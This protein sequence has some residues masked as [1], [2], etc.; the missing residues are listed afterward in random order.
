MRAGKTHNGFINLRF[1]IS[2]VNAL[3]LITVFISLLVQADGHSHL[4]SQTTF[5]EKLAQAD[6]IRS[7]QPKK[8]VKL[9][10]QL[11]QQTNGITDSQQ[12]SLDY[13]NIYLLMYQGDLAAAATAAKALINSDT[14]ALLKFRA[15]IALVNAYGVSQNWTEGLSSL[16]SMLA[17]LPLIDEK[18]SY[19][20]GILI[21]AIFYNQIGQYH[22]GLSYA[23]KAESISKHGR[24][25]CIAKAQIIESSFKLKQLTSTSPIIEHAISIC[26]IND[27]PLIINFIHSYVAKLYLENQQQDKALS[28]LNATLED[29]LNTNYSRIIAEYYA[30]LAQAHWLNNNANLTKQF[31]LKVLEYEKKENTT[32]AKVSAYK[33]LFEVYRTQK[34]YE[35]ALL[36]H[37]KFAIADKLYDSETQAKHLAFQ[38]AEHKSIAQQSKIDLLSQQNAL[39][40]SEQAL[41]R[42]NTEKTRL[43]IMVLALTLAVLTFWGYRLL[44]AHKLIKKMAEYDAL[45]D[46]F[47]RGHFTHVANNTIEY[48]QSTEQALSVIMFDL[49][50]FKK[51]NDNYGHACGDWALKKA[52]MVCQENSRQNDVFARLGGEEFCIILTGCDKRAALKHAEICRLAIANID[53]SESGF[54][55]NITASFGITDS[56]TSGYNLEKLLADADEAAYQAKDLGRN[57]ISIYENE[58][59]SA[60]VIMLEDSPKAT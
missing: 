47:N 60:T 45:T 1:V 7:S 43:I 52:V 46:I 37:Q 36:Y 20:Q 44:N 58:Q 5:D 10:K 14:S 18:K 21:S 19:A 39:L 55:F 49:D 22:L 2:S 51:V 59:M 3:I 4:N 27:E 23:K 11:N 33:L 50:H 32:L 15:Q 56:D 13:L 25:Q 35:L 42:A 53:T 54:E 17:E 48:C 57:Q 29:T 30:L 26:R 12:F 8:F 28:L 41:S 6:A 34:N 31:A 40:K 16:S 9:I 24:D 38:L